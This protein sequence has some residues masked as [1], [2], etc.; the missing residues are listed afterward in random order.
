MKIAVRLDDITPDM[1]WE[2]FRRLEKLL[3]QYK[4]APLIGI[5]P[6]NQDSNLKKDAVTADFNL[7]IKKWED[8]EWTFAMHGW[9]HLYT[10]KKGGVFPLN[11]FSEFA[12][13]P[14]ERQREML[15]DGKKKFLEMGII[16]Q[17]FMAP[18]HSF[19]KNTLRVLKELGFQY[20][21]DGFGIRPYRW[22]GLKFLPIAFQKNKDIEKKE[23]Y[24]TLVFHTNTMKEQDFTAFE[25]VLEKHQKDFISFKEYLEV[26]AIRQTL[27]GRI[28]EY[29]MAT[30][31]RLLVKI[32]TMRR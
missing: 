22:Q 7:Q 19:D 20:I 6:D 16:P 31:K 5:V 3:D 13:V 11:S 24:T 18:G 30:L 17:I 8:K 9:R 28:R 15:C 23:G 1:N 10:T 4:I 2:N 25:K 21:T 29:G 32:Y 14:I 27:V 12:G 26:S